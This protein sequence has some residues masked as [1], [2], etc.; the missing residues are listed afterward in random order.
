MSK[1]NVAVATTI[2]QQLGGNK[3]KVMTGAKNIFA[4]GN[5][6]SFQLPSRGAAKGINHVHIILDPSDTYTVIF[7]KVVKYTVK[8]IA[9]YSDIYCDMLQSLFTRETGLDTHL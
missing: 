1:D 2:L 3:F 5:G 4:N 8:E 9:R 7:N 6:L